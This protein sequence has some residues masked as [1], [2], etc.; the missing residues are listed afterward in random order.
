MWLTVCFR[1]KKTQTCDCVATVLPTCLFPLLSLNLKYGK[2]LCLSLPPPS[3]LF[4]RA[5]ERD[6]KCLAFSLKRNH[7][8]KLILCRLNWH[9]NPSSEEGNSESNLGSAPTLSLALEA[10]RQIVKEVGGGIIVK[11][12]NA[13]KKKLILSASTVQPLQISFGDFQQL[14]S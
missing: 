2:T 12:R 11:I 1:D 13:S 3:L 4:W 6:R 7:W 5:R 8:N 14:V 10:Q 9:G